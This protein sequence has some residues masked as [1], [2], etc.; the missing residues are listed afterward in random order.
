[1]NDAQAAAHRKAAYRGLVPVCTVEYL[2]QAI[3]ARFAG[4]EGSV[5][6]WAVDS[7]VREHRPAAADNNRYTTSVR[8][9]FTPAAE[10]DDV[11]AWKTGY[12]YLPC[13]PLCE[14]GYEGGGLNPWVV[15]FTV[16]KASS[17]EVAEAWQSFIGHVWE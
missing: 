6:L 5:R 9:R 7:Q 17:P 15:P 13:V 4:C 16:I 8:I 3:A 11:G 2:R 14:D 12:V 10:D 1:M